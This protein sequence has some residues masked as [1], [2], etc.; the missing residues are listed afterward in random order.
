MKQESIEKWRPLRYGD[1]KVPNYE[2]SSVG[3]IR[4]I[5]HYVE[6]LRN[7]KPFKRWVNGI[8]LKT[9]VGVF[10]YKFTEVRFENTKFTVYVHKAVYDSF[11]PHE[12]KDYVSFKDGDPTNCFLS[13]LYPI[14]HGE[15]QLKNLEKYPENRWRL[16]RANTASGYYA[17]GGRNNKLSAEDRIRI[18]QLWK[19]G[20][21]AKELAKIF[22]IA[23]SSTYRYKN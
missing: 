13:N 14:T 7:G 4:S 8:I 15:L 9:R 12:R 19:E 18:R 5:G 23:L 16:A 3:R 1:R 6:C 20:V 2:V 17:N 11:H 22:G 21:P 10:P